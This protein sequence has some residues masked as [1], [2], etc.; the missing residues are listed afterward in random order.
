MGAN[1]RR[2]RN[3]EFISGLVVGRG[4]QAPRVDY[5]APDVA[6]LISSETQR[7]MAEADAAPEEES[8]T[9]KASPG[10][11]ASRRR[12]QK[13]KARAR[14]IASDPQR[15]LEQENQANKRSR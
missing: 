15:L 1:A 14:G 11:T 6:A 5:V 4:P 7:A 2:R 12:A 3:N 10:E 9:P 8:D 13:A